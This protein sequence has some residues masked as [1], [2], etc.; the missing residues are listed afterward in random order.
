MPSIEME[1][2]MKTSINAYCLAALVLISVGVSPVVGEELALKPQGNLDITIPTIDISDETDRHVIIAQGTDKTYQGH[3][4]TVLLEDGKTVYAVWTYN[5]GGPCGPLK[6]STD[7][8]RTWSELLPVPDNWTS[9]TNCPSI[10]RLVDPAGK[11]RLIVFASQMKP[12]KP[13]IMWQSISED[14]GKT[15]SEMKT[16]GIKCVMPFCSIVPIDGGKKL[17]AATNQRRPGDPNRY[18]NHVAQWISSDGGLT[19][20]NHKVICDVPVVIPCEPALVRSP[21]GKQLLCIMRANNKK[22]N[23]LFIVSDDEGR[24]WSRPKEATASVTGDRHAMRYAP[25]GRLVICFRDRAPRSPSRKHYAAWVGCYEDIV[26][27]REGQYRIKLLHSNA[28]RDCGYVAL[29]LLPDGNFLSTTYV[30]YHPGPKRHS[31]VSTRFNLPEID[32]ICERQG[33]SHRSQGGRSSR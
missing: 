4:T 20:G 18:S 29:E 19:W 5:H 9:V 12:K 1:K 31:V 24:T 11:A 7:G 21:N 15:W 2:F 27:G 28:G 14:N 23:S 10:Y 8:G 16:M 33:T 6:K 25:D 32:A 26:K 22:Y 3:P 30:K 17:L 13:R